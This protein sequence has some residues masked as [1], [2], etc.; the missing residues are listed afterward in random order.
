MLKSNFS[1]STSQLRQSRYIILQTIESHIYLI[2][3]QY[4]FVTIGTLQTPRPKLKIWKHIT[5]VYF[6]EKC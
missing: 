4:D 6:A 1:E 3:L 5:T 2:S